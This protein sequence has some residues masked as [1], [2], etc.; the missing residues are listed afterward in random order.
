MH[1]LVIDDDAD[2]RRMVSAALLDDDVLTAPDGIVGLDILTYTDVDA[3]LL[4][5]M[6]PLL[7][8]FAVLRKIRRDDRT[9]DV[10]VIMLTAKAGDRDHAA[11]FRAGADAYLT[12][13]FDIDD[14]EATLADVAARSPGQREALRQAEL[15]RAELLARIEQT[16]S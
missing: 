5:V 7:D 11:A 15:D 2:V 9:R 1:V 8:G 14:L 16:F 4:D 6:M 13:P 12:K 3:V 10:P